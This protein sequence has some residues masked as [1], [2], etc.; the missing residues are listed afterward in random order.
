MPRSPEG[1][2][3]LRV[4]HA[5]SK[6][7]P[8]HQLRLLRHPDRLGDRGARRIPERGRPRRLHGRQG[9]AR[10]AVPGDAG[11]DHERFVRAL[12]RG[13]AAYG[14]QV[15]PGSGVGPGALARPVPP[16]LDPALASVSRD[17]RPA[18]ALR[19]EVR[20][21]ADLEHRRQASGRHAPALPGRLGPG[22]DGS[23]GALVQARPGPLQGVRAADRRQEGLG[24]HRVGLRSRCR[25][26]HQGQDP[27]HLGEPARA[28][29]RVEPEE[30]D[31][32]G[33]E[34]PRSGEAPGSR[35]KVVAVSESAFVLTSSLWQTNA[36]ALRSGEEAMLIDSPYFPDELEMVPEILRQSGFEPA[37][38]LATHGDWDHLLARLVFPEHSLGVA[39][40]T[41]VRIRSAPG[42]AQRD[43][44]KADNEYYVRRPRPL[45]LGSYQPL[46]VPG[47]LELGSEELELYPAEGQTDDGMILAA[48]W[49]GVLVCGDYLS[50]VELPTWSDK[51]LYRKTLDRLRPL[52]EEAT[53]VVPGH[54]S[55]MPQDEALRVLEDD[56][57]YLDEG[58]VPKGRFTS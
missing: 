9:H 48:R 37:G 22:R 11:R 15:R 5:T 57:A 30:A 43:L 13:H 17:Q 55:P 28:E 20:D 21:R 39:E 47:K 14:D 1:R 12:R 4:R 23:A 27:G 49:L 26:L 35:L 41:G 25:A 50:D 52:V 16:R 32:G 18:R 51:D 34:P 29:A 38:L 36:V 56:I 6:G 58:T 2:G 44:R 46:P 8:L 31:R 19:E 42:E 53:V 40:S 3:R 54:G 45:S 10:A 33:Q 7:H 24:A